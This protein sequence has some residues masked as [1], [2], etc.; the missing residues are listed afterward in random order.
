MDQAILW[1]EAVI[2][3][4]LSGTRNTANAVVDSSLILQV[5]LAD[6]AFSTDVDRLLCFNDWPCPELSINFL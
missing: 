1:I 3:S 2:R 4:K 6:S 5:V